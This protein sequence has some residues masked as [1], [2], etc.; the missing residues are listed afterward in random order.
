M[1]DDI[2]VSSSSLGLATAPVLFAIEEH[3]VL[4]VMAARNFSK[5]G[6]TR[7]AFD[8]VLHSQGLARH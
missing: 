2:S 5:L 8:L 6:D 1:R 4:R 7:E 3:P